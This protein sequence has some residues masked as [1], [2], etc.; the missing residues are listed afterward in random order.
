M[1][2]PLSTISLVISNALGLDPETS[3]RAS[4]IIGGT[5]GGILSGRFIKNMN[6][7]QFFTGIVA[8]VI[9]ADMLALP[10]ARYFDVPDWAEKIAFMIGLF[11]LSIV[12][13]I[14][15]AIKKSDIWKLIEKR[16]GADSE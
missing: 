5:L 6:R 9:V 16:F 1:S 7:W 11:G 15:D 13:A 14:F 4:V 10:T 2:E 3:A 12:G 8:G